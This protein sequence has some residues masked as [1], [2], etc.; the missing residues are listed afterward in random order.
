M[1]LREIEKLRVSLYRVTPTQRVRTM[2]AAARFIKRV[3]FCWLF[4]PAPG[5]PELPSLFEAVKGRRGVHI[6]DWDEDSDR[7]WVWKNDLPAAH[8]A[9]Y[10]KALLGRPSF[11]SLELLPYLIASSGEENFAQQYRHGGISYDAKKIYDALE[12]LGPRPTMA[13][14]RAAGIEGKD[15]NTR[16]HRALDELQRELY[17]LPVGATRE[18]GNWHSQIFELTARWFPEQAEAAH[19]ID[20]H[21]AWRTLAT[22]YLKTVVVAKPAVLT[23][24]FNIPREQLDGVIKELTARRVARV[25]DGWLVKMNH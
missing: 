4:A 15:A 8:R 25:E 18:T 9:Y 24:L 7:V 21:E 5:T 19:R 12:Q 1:N 6:F 23:R 22:R 13:L 3:G 20:A 2:N 10:G 16:Y 14:R 17:I 11:I